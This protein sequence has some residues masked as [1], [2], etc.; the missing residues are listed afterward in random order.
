MKMIKGSVNN[1]RSGLR[2][3]LNKLKRKTTRMRV[4]PLSK[5]IPEEVNAARSTPSAINVQRRR[6]V[7]IFLM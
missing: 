2:M 4:L 3:R 1:T 5:S 6:S 7:L